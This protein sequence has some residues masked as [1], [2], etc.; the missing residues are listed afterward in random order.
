M[1]YEKIKYVLF[2]MITVDL[3]MKLTT[4]FKFSG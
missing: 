3:A 1:L 2:Y 4:Y